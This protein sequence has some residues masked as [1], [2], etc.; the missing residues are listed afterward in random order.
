V[1]FVALA[2]RL[3]FLA[4]AAALSVVLAG[5]GAARASTTAR[6]VYLRGAGTESCPDESELREAVAARLGYDAFTPLSF[7]TLF[8]EVDKDGTGFVARVKLVSLDNS[9]RGARTLQTTGPCADLMASLALTISIAIDPM[10]GARKGPPEGLPPAERQVEVGPSEPSPER[11]IDDAPVALPAAPAPVPSP[12]LRF[13]MGAG[14]FGSIGYAPGAAVGFAVFGRMRLG[15][16]SLGLEGRADLPAGADVSGGG[17]VQ[18]SLLAVSLSPC[19]HVGVL[20]GC[21][22]GSL[23]RLHA[24][25]ADVTDPRSTGELWAAVGLRGGAELALGHA[26]ALRVHVDADALVTR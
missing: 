20:F 9:V 26:V 3:C 23:G 22:R 18:S 13:A 10:A 25:G 21:A 16:A 19:G 15:D 2:P 5:E 14:T 24:E 12:R 6:L 11:P 4:A 1:A 17:H 7:D 8:T